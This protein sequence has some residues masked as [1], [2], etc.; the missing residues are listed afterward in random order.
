VRP[1]LVSGNRGQVALMPHGAEPAP[2]G[3]LAGSL[4]RWLVVR[5]RIESPSGRRHAPTGL[6]LTVR[7][8]AASYVEHAVSA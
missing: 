4:V 5:S 2:A 8:L 1:L 6:P 7:C 3:H